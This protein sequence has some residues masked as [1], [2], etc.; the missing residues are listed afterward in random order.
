VSGPRSRR[1]LAAILSADVVGHSRL[2]AADEA[3]TVETL[4]AYRQIVARLV[5]R[6]GGR[7]VNAPGDALLA[8]FPSAVEAVQAAV[9]AQKALEGHN[10]ELEPDRRMQF[11]IGVNVGDVIEEADGTL[12]G[13]GVNIAA[14]M[15]ALADAGGVCVSSTV[16][17]AVEGKL[18]LGFDFLGEQQVKNIAKPVRVYRVRAEPR[19][20][21]ARM[22]ARRRVRRRVG[23]PVI[24]A[25][26]LVVLIAAGALGWQLLRARAPLE[27]PVLALPKGPS[28]AVLPFENLSGDPAQDFFAKGVA[29]EISAELSRSPDVAIVGHGATAGI[30]SSLDVKKVAT[31]LHVQFLLKG[32]VRK[33]ADRVR[34]TAELIQGA[35]GRQVWTHSYDRPLDPQSLIAVQEDIAQQVVA[36]VAG[37]YGVVS[38]L[39][40]K[41][42]K[43]VPPANLSSYECVLLFYEYFQGIAPEPHRRVRDCLERAVARDPNYA[44]AWG[45]LAIVYAH[46]HAMGFNP[47]PRPL[48]RALEAAQHGVQADPNSQL[49]YEGLAAAYFFSH[50]RERFGKA[51]EREVA[52]NPNNEPTI[53]NIGFYFGMWGM[54][55]RGLP[56]LKKAIKLNPYHPGWYWFPFWL[57]AYARGE[58]EEAL[59]FAEKGNRPSLFISYAHLA[60]TYA[61]LGRKEQAAQELRTLLQLR[62]DYPERMR[63][64][65]RF[66]NVSEPVSDKIAEG[67]RKAGWRS[68][69]VRPA[70]QH[71][72]HARKAYWRRALASYRRCP[73][74]NG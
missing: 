18:A 35:D 52:L 46:E 12:Y 17:D 31:D 68:P 40:R 62:P 36:T 14:R 37:G 6:H 30:S 25:A 69:T 66:W 58:Y 72:H 63:E 11:R 48:E 65:G 53:G 32:G 8:E 71:T 49:A 60:A 41:R 27:D 61:R 15:E 3:A 57:Q 45:R 74:P 10:I 19:T 21:P 43:K 13:D 22:G 73:E 2:M 16:Y 28:M 50:D 7:V 20:R 26:A 59:D 51:A 55:D 54:Y 34:V 67:L 64:L 9:D 33:A 4:K 56:L 29:A 24:G 23:R 44:D 5:A 38:Q 1:K 47:R 70:E 42:A 39:V